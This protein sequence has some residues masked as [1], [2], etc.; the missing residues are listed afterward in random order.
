MSKK[1]TGCVGGDDNEKKKAEK[2]F[3][4]AIGTRLQL[5]NYSTFSVY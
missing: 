1:V 4:R 2:H 3:S 5:L